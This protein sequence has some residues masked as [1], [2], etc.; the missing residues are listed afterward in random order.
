MEKFETV[1]Y[2]DQIWMADNYLHSTFSWD[3]AMQIQL[4]GWRL[5]TLEDFR[6]LQSRLVSSS[7]PYLS[8]E[9]K[10]LNL[11]WDDFNEYKEPGEFFSVQVNRMRL[12]SATQEENDKNYAHA[13]LIER[14]HGVDRG[15]G[16]SISINLF[17]TNERLP[18][19]L[20]KL[21]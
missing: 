21:V 18:V 14:W 4:E 2:G 19:R 12:W 15:E 13:F 9:G 7:S 5:P 8:D 16:G 1:R 17:S 6:V 11:T 3:G 20:I 10:E